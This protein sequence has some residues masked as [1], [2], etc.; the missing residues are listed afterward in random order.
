M[1]TDRQEVRTPGS[2]RDEQEQ[3]KTS[4]RR[5]LF[6]WFL[7]IA[8]ILLAV[9]LIG[10]GIGATNGLAVVLLV[11]SGI[12]LVA[13]SLGLFMGKQIALTIMKIVW[14]L[15]CVLVVVSAFAAWSYA[16]SPDLSHGLGLVLAL[17][18]S[19]IWLAS[20]KTFF[21]TRTVAGAMR[22]VAKETP[23]WTCDKCG[24]PNT[25]FDKVKC[26]ACGAPKPI[27]E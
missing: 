12:G 5:P 19:P 8:I 7:A 24:A 16:G 2:S 15:W 26:A 17:V 25:R 10:G 20:I 6:I 23:S 18:F 13:L 14:V 9:A 21:D 11:G 27:V 3:P 1:N 4:A 22:R